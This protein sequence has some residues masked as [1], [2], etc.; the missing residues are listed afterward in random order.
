MT[1]NRAT[2]DGTPA[3]ERLEALGL[4]AGGIAHELS[5]PLLAITQNVQFASESAGQFGRL[6]AAADDL[7]RANTAEFEAR[8]ATYLALR[9]D[10][11]SRGVLSELEPALADAA[12]AA[13][14]A[15]TLVRVLADYDEASSVDGAVDVNRVLDSMIQ[16]ARN[17][18]KHVADVRR[19]FDENLPAALTN[20][21]EL[22]LRC[23]RFIVE[24]ARGIQRRREQEPE[25]R[26][27]I[28]VSSRAR[29]GRI[30]LA[31]SHEGIPEGVT[32]P[33][34]RRHGHVDGAA[35]V[36]WAIDLPSVT[37][38]DRRQHGSVHQ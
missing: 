21:A 15:A 34:V 23:L 28:E 25:W 1:D 13:E 19:L 16:L 29:D 24:A 5:S 3:A 35:R 4:L 14:R 36:T 11:D 12:L 9:A 27:E 8:R 18:W 17:A 2:T 33:L 37:V 30:E 22:S 38:P 32:P 26:G 31:I 20:E 7:S 10:L 6:L